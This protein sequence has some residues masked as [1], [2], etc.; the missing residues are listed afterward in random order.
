MHWAHLLLH[1]RE[2][3]A[4]LWGEGRGR[5]REHLHA[6]R[7]SRRG[8]RARRAPHSS[9]S[10]P[11]QRRRRPRRPRRPG[12]RPRRRRARHPRLVQPIPQPTR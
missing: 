11:R 2:E 4:H 10:F 1:L 12:R 7:S 5:R 6:G 8:V 9:S 3:C